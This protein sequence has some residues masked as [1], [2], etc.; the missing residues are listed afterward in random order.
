M[1]TIRTRV[2]KFDELSKDAQEYAVK[3]WLED[4]TYD[5]LFNEA[6]ETVK[7]F[8]DI[9][10]INIRQYDFLEHYRSDYRLDLDD[11][12]LQLS[13]SRLLS[14]LW[15]NYKDSLFKGKYYSVKSDK[16]LKHKRVKSKKLSNGN[17]FNAY[18]SAIQLDHSCV[19]TGVYYDDCILEPIYK[20]LDHPDNSDL[21][22]L[23]EECFVQINKAV[24]SE[25]QYQ[26]SFEAVSKTIRIN[27][28]EFYKDGRM[29]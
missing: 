22:D 18:Y 3:K 12:I 5:Y 11:N 14:Y 26:S 13:G 25:I 23:L 24:E 16:E 7:R 1:R 19:L 20:F 4:E 17:I 15:N 28:Y 27:E 6:Y 8:A 9:F 10:D 29:L 21:N 2:Y